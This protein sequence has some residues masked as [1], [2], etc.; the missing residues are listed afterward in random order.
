MEVKQL[1]EVS[2]SGLWA[3]CAGVLVSGFRD[4]RLAT[5]LAGLHWIRAGLGLGFRF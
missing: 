1:S 4:F 2:G 5:S 3:E